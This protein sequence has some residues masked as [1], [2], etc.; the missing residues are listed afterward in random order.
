M[1]RGG[2]NDSGFLVTRDPKFLTILVS[3][4]C[5]LILPSLQQVRLNGVT[6]FLGEVLVGTVTYQA[7]IN[8]DM[9]SFHDISRCGRVVTAKGGSSY[10][11]LAEVEVYGSIFTG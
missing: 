2:V 8:N 5:R 3:E 9:Y 11:T 7:G 4:L 1:I 10:I 6:V